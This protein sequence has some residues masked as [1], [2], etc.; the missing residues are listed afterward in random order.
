MPFGLC[1]AT[2]TS[3]RLMNQVFKPL[4]GKFVVVYFDDMLVFSKPEEEH[5]KHLRKV[6]MVL[7]QEQLVGNLKKCFFFTLEV[8]FLG[9]IISAQGK[10]V[11]QSKINVIK[12]LAC[13]HFHA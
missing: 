13:S 3:M 7:K 11:D 12:I 2:S 10:Q 6:I 4:L 9:Y 5:L 8:V 1:N